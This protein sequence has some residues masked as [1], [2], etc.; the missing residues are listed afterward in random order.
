MH[1]G[2]CRAI[3]FTSQRRQH[4]PQCL[5]QRYAWLNAIGVIEKIACYVGCQK[6]GG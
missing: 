3:R 4:H 5:A 6:R 1:G 2:R